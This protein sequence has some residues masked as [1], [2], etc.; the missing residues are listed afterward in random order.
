MRSIRA[1]SNSSGSKCP[2]AECASK[3]SSAEHFVRIAQQRPHQALA[4]RIER[5]DVLQIDQ[6]YTTDRNLVRLTDCLMADLP[7]RR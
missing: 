1:V 4:E 2:A 7:I 3:Y 6:Y 5:H